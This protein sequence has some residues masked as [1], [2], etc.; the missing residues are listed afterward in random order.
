[1]SSRFFT[2]QPCIAH[3]ATTCILELEVKGQKA[4]VFLRPISSKTTLAKEKQRKN[5]KNKGKE[6]G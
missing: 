1:M 3:F 2:H 4:G 5:R 6:K